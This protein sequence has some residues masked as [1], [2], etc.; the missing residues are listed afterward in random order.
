[1]WDLEVFEVGGGLSILS[2]LLRCIKEEEEESAT[3]GEGGVS[4]GPEANT[5]SSLIGE[6]ILL[7]KQ[8][9]EGG[10]VVSVGI[11]MEV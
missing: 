7:V 1:M 10:L 5:I 3:I 9:D 8:E 6:D 4:D 2:M 11:G